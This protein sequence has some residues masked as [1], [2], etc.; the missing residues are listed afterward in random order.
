MD[1]PKVGL[2]LGSG[3][4]R[5]FA[6]LGVLKVLEENNIPVDYLAGS[7]MGALIAC[8]YSFGHNIEMLIKL[9]VAFRKKYYLDFTVPKMG[10]IAGKKVKNLV[11]Y[12]VHNKRLEE[13]NIPVCVIATDLQT[14]EKVEFFQGPIAE[15]VRASISIPGIFSPEKLNGRLLVDGGVVDR[16]PVSTVKKMGADI[17]IGCDVA[18]VNKEAEILTVYD[19]IMQSLDILQLE[20]GI[21]RE[22]ESDVMIHPA[23]EMYSARAFKNIEEIIK[24]GEEDARRK[25]PEIQ[26]AIEQFNK[27]R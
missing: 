14:G 7:S 27:N 19:V 3:G 21:A 8:F 1:M 24:A 16:V 11:R 20:I 5:G 12:F 23:V 22:Y 4:A 10:F 6:H 9:S 25:L 26:K 13:L 18:T 15:S 2:A 17:V